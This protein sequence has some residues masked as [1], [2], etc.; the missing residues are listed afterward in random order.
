[1]VSLSFPTIST[2][3]ITLWLPFYQAAD[4]STTLD[5]VSYTTVEGRSLEGYTLY[6]SLDSTTTYLGGNDGDN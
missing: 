2:L 3:S 4:S 1:M 6:A 5:S